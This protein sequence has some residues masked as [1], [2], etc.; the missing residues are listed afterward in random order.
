MNYIGQ[1]AVDLLSSTEDLA[2]FSCAS[3][4]PLN[5]GQQVDSGVWD[6]IEYGE[7]ENFVHGTIGALY[8]A[9]R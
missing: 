8:M 9:C 4:F 2:K 6:N 3:A 5:L 7:R 1:L